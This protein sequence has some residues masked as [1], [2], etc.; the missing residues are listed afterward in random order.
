[1]ICLI[2][3]KY[4]EQLV[5]MSRGIFIALV[6]PF[7]FNVFAFSQ[8][9]TTFL[10]NKESFKANRQKKWIGAVD[11][12]GL[13]DRIIMP[14]VD[15]ISKEIYNFDKDNG[16][17]CTDISLSHKEY[18]IEMYFYVD[19]T[20]KRTKIVDFSNRTED[21][22]VF[23]EKGKLLVNQIRSESSVFSSED[24]VHFI[25]TRAKNNR[26]SVYVNEEQIVSYQDDAEDFVLSTNQ[27]AQFFIND[28]EN[29]AQG[30]S[31]AIGLFKIYPYVFDE[32]D[33]KDVKEYLPK[34]LRGELDNVIIR[35]SLKN[36]ATKGSIEGAE[37]IVVSMDKGVKGQTHTNNNGK[38]SLI[39]SPGSTYHVEVHKKGFTDFEEDIVL[40]RTNKYL[41]VELIPLQAGQT[42]RLE[43]VYFKKGKSKVLKDSHNELNKLARLMIENT[44]MRIELGGHTDNLGSAD[45]SLKLSE[46]RV[47]SVKQYLADQGVPKSRIEGKGYGGSKPISNNSTEESRRKNRR[48]EF[49]ILKFE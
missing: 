18:T 25:F 29:R 19:N 36:A 46:D 37:V 14:K 47:A 6:I 49:T 31:G 44:K 30:A 22:G 35:G 27:I 11:G 32:Q 48:V 1:M 7:I 40:T 8:G 45:L 4:Y 38:F 24:Y 42:I 5:I 10:F 13:F 17:M 3:P 12:K 21:K 23:I 43:S 15:F 26:I 41:N 39:G 28:C 20:G 34:T 33:V 16:I 2:L 9:E